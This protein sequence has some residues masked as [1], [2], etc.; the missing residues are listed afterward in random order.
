MGYGIKIEISGEYALFTRPELKVERYSYEIITPSAARGVLEAVYFKPQ[1]KWKINKI[2]IYNALKFASFKRNEVS[3][4]ILESDAKKMMKG[5]KSAKGYLNTVDKIQQRSATVLKD[6]RYI[7]EAE[8]SMTG[9][10]SREDDTKEK[11]YN[12]I[13]RRLRKGQCFH[14]PYLGCREF[15]AKVKIVEDEIEKSSLIGEKDLGFMLLDMDYSNLD[16]ITPIFFRAKMID[17]VVDV[18]NAVELR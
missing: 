18:K 3:E 11:H 6:V 15:P 17:G 4:K 8:F 16:N 9:I 7:I 5:S 10:K 13:L 2:H 14:Q 12:M 1:I